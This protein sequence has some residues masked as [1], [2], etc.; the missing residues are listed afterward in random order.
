MHST[1]GWPRAIE[2]VGGRLEGLYNCLP[3]R[4]RLP[5]VDL[6]KEDMQQSSGL[7]AAR[8][9][10]MWYCVSGDDEGDNEEDAL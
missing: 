4:K 1:T 5:S 8:L 2:V 7:D 9:E 10:L 6:E 3:W